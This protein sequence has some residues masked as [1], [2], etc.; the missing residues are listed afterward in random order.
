MREVEMTLENLLFKKRQIACITT[1][2]TNGEDG[3]MDHY[4]STERANN[5]ASRQ[6]TMEEEILL[7]ASF[8]R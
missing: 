3:T 6:Y 7:S 2:R 8:P 4:M 1:S 5:E